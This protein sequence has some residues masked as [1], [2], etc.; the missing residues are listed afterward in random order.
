M[1]AELYIQILNDELMNTLEYHGLTPS[2][3]QNNEPKHTYRKVRDWLGEQDFR[4]MVWP[5]QSAE[6]NPIEHGWHCLKKRLAEYKTPPNGIEKLLE[7][8]QV[9]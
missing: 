8:I 5:P 2:D 6:L 7:R 1:D 4:T 9:E 3:E